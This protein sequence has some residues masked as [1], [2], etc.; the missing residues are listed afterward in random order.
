MNLGSTNLSWHMATYL[1]IV[2]RKNCGQLL[3]WLCYHLKIHGPPNGLLLN[4]GPQLF[5][6]SEYFLFCCLMILA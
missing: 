2:L 1:L 3:L 5:R 4:S 6:A